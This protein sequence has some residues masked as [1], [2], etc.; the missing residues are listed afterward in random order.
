MYYLA[1]FRGT[2]DFVDIIN[3]IEVFVFH[4]CH[5][6]IVM[7]EYMMSYASIVMREYMMSY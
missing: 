4:F 7:R 5:V 2:S 6:S 3:T 1:I